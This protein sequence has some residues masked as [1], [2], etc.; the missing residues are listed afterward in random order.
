MQVGKLYFCL[1]ELKK[2]KNV[3]AFG[4]KNCF[5]NANNQYSKIFGKLFYIGYEINEKQ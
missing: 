5:V 3:N 1:T 4:L 2:I